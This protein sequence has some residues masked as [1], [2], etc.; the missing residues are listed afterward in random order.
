ML[1]ECADGSVMADQV[2]VATD[3]HATQPR[4]SDDLDPQ[5]IHLRAGEYR[6]LSQLQTGGVLV[7]GAGSSLGSML[8][9]LLPK[10]EN[11]LTA[12]RDDR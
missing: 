3:I 2:I 1:V 5:L 8:P 10:T 4:P 12:S 11:H 7:V 9:T 6:S